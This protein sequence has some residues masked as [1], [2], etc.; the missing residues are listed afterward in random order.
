MATNYKDIDKSHHVV[1]SDN[2]W[3]CQRVCFCG[4][5]YKETFISGIPAHKGKIIYVR[6]TK[7]IYWIEQYAIEIE[8]K[9]LSELIKSELL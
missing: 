5:S 2:G 3:I 9:K 1:L 7:N 8:R 6:P 4:G